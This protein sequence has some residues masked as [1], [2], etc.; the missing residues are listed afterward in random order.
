MLCSITDHVIKALVAGAI[1]LGLGQ[2]YIYEETEKR[3]KCS[4]MRIQRRYHKCGWDKY[5]EKILYSQGLGTYW[6]Y[7]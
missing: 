5:T 4:R 6:C 1:A 7:Q 3:S 2:E